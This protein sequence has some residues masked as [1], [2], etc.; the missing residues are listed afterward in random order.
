MNFGRYS[1][2]GRAE[3]ARAVD[4]AVAKALQPCA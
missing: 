3:V 2:G 4:A 1:A